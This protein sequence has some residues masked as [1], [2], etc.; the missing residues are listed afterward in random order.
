MN[1]FKKTLAGIL[2]GAAFLMVSF[3]A[4]AQSGSLQMGK[5][6][7]AVCESKVIGHQEACTG[8][9]MGVI[10][11]L[12][13]SSIANAHK[14]SICI[15]DKKV[16]YFQARDSIIAHIKK[17]PENLAKDSPRL[18]VDSLKKEYPCS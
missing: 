10:D 16:S 7:L 13:M 6:L 3:A 11:T 17:D 5:E 18:I 8:Y 4:S 1:F 2:V 14:K 15:M 9:I 12:L